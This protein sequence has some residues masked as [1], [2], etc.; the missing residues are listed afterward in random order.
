MTVLN[1][2]GYSGRQAK[3]RVTVARVAYPPF[4]KRGRTMWNLSSSSCGG[5]RCFCDCCWLGVL[6]RELLI[7]AFFLQQQAVLAPQWRSPA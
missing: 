5:R 1:R 7:G 6:P 2:S 4:V 3:H